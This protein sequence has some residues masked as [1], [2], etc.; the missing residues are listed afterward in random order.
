MDD[1]IEIK[2]TSLCPGDKPYEEFWLLKII[3][4]HQDKR[5]RLQC[6]TKGF[7]NLNLIDGR[8]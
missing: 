2:Y 6:D 8:L 5:I 3:P 7:M 4:S 1:D